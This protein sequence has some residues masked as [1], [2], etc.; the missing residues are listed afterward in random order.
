VRASTRRQLKEDQFTAAA[1]E[2]YSW[3][4]E[5]RGKLVYSGAAVAAVLLI[6]FGG[7]FYIQQQD[8]A[9][10]VALGHAL[11]VYQAPVTGSGQP[12]L[13]ET[14]T[15]AS[16]QDRAKAARAEFAKV[17]DKYSRTNSGKIARY[18]MGLADKEAGNTAAAETELKEVADSGR[19][20]VAALGKFAL[21]SLYFGQG[22]EAQAV[23]L[24]KDL[25]EHPTNTVA[26][27]QAQLALASVYEQKQ[28]QDARNLYQQVQK[29]NPNSPAA[30]MAAGRLSEMK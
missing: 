14:T 30:Q 29:E 1:Q 24:Y 18:F 12:P 20:D 27:S 9:A 3:A 25:I 26:K 21:A 5:H 23:P 19:S 15:F 22:K 10:G 13:P 17:A 11:K 28:P 6:V 7:W 8:E 16:A 2:T 4:V